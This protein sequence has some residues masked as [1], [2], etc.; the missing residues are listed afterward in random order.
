ML[1]AVIAILLPSVF[2]LK[3]LDYLKRGISLKNSFYYY[4][5][6]LLGSSFINNILSYFFFDINS[7]F[8]DNFIY[9][10]FFSKYVLM[11]VF[12][13]TIIVLIIIVLQNNIQLE[14]K[15]KKVGDLNGKSKK[16]KN[17]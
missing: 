11:S 14:V 1:Y 15:V 17:S 16:K 6:L 7:N 4:M 9:P 8:I 5:I 13:N 10:I 3:L 2:G 12:V